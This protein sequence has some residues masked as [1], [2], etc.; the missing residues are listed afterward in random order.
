MKKRILSLTLIIQLGFSCLWAQWST[1]YMPNPRV[2]FSAT[3]TGGVV[4]F[5]PG[6]N[7]GLPTPAIMAYTPRSNKWQRITLPGSSRTFST[8]LAASD[9]KIYIAGGQSTTFSPIRYESTVNIYQPDQQKFAQANLSEARVVGAALEVGDRLLFAGGKRSNAPELYSSRV[10]V[11]NL[12]TQIWSRKELSLARV[13]IAAGTN[14]TVAIFAGGELNNNAVT[15]VIDVYLATSDTWTTL[16]LSEA[17]SYASCVVFDN[18]AYI[19]GGCFPNGMAS[20]K[21]EILD[22]AN[23]SF[24]PNNLRISRARC[25]SAAH[26]VGDKIV[27]AAGG[28][29]DFQGNVWYDSFKEVDILDP[30]NQTLRRD[31]LQFDR[32]NHAAAVL[33][34]QLYIAG[35][36]SMGIPLET[37]REVEVYRPTLTR[38][39]SITDLPKLKVHPNPVSNGSVVIETDLQFFDDNLLLRLLD[40]NGQVILEQMMNAPKVQVELPDLPK[41][42]YVFN[43]IGSKGTRNVSFMIF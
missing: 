11:F 7:N 39:R 12:K 2:Q 22:L 8:M 26:K 3:S 41:G 9:G 16:Q 33:D 24:I 4:Y 18:K 32:I 43:L 34:D 35:G 40:L 37:I 13:G 19:I 25:G 36:L 6:N 17:K 15:N 42:T 14:G 27:V 30:K 10:D 20:D 21:V 29:L 5:G 31:Q 28:L 38:S 1:L 23:L